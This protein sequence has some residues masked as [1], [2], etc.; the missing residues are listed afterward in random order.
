[1]V[2]AAGERYLWGEKN[3]VTKTPFRTESGG[4]GMWVVLAAVAASLLALYSTLRLLR[5]HHPDL[6]QKPIPQLHFASTSQVKFA[7][8]ESGRTSDPLVLV[9]HGFPDTAASFCHLLPSLA[10]QGELPSPIPAAVTMLHRPSRLFAAGPDSWFVSAGY[11]AVAPYLPGYFP[12]SLAA[13]DN[14]SLVPERSPFFAP[15]MHLTFDYPGCSISLYRA[16]NCSPRPRR[17][18]HYRV[19][20][21]SIV[22]RLRA[23]R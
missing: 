17:C 4:G 1:M 9:I 23:K 11:R 6:R 14:Y 18:C 5:R 19:R 12:S 3:G 15:G 21:C 13:D 7:Y 16:F 2:R 10:A 8:H 22:I 20:R